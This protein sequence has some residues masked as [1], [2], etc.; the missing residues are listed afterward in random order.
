MSTR[1]STGGGDSEA[2]A[3]W[4]RRTEELQ[5]YVNAARGP[6]SRYYQNQLDEHLKKKPAK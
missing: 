6:E 3:K 2:M 4:R 5:R 1:S